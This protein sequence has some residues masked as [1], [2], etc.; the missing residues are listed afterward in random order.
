VYDGWGCPL[1]IYDVRQNGMTAGI[2]PYKCN[3]IGIVDVCGPMTTC[4]LQIRKILP[5][6]N[7]LLLAIA[8]KL[9]NSIFNCE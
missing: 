4:L 6:K 8:T 2:Q 7:L 3:G 1:V 5:S 9:E